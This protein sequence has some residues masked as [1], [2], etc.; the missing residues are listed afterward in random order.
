MS[1]SAPDSEI[2]IC[3]MALSHLKQAPITQI[4]PP[5]SGV[6]ER[7]ALWYHQIRQE[8]LRSHSWNF[9][10]ARTQISPDSS[11]EPPFGF[12]H[13]YALPSNWLRFLG[14]YDDLGTR[15]QN[16]DYD[17]EG[18]YLLLNGEDN[19]SINVRYI[20]DFKTV[21]QMDA[22][23]R[24][25]F[26]INLAIVLAPNFSGSEARVKTILEIRKDLEAKATAIDGQERP[27]RRIQRSKFIE[28]RKGGM[29]GMSAGP[30]TVFSG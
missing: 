19:A 21:I 6:E 18:R 7:C 25:L 30:H 14:R 27:P 10:I 2:D 13:A 8:T 5:S 3:N 23:F 16:D 24:G 17:I 1:L 28:A 12:S 22:L 29:G 26:A 15:V 20:T 4:D 11:A 9:A